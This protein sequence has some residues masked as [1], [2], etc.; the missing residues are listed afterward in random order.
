MQYFIIRH[1]ETNALL[2]TE[3]NLT[4][5]EA[6][7]ALNETHAPSDYYITE[8][9]GDGVS[10]EDDVMIRKISGCQFLSEDRQEQRIHFQDDAMEKLRRIAANAQPFIG[11]IK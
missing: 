4:K 2:H 1:K 3:P 10:F 5:H 7:S 11:L 6:V 8:W 9:Q